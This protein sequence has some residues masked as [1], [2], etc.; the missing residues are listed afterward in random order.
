MAISMKRYIDITSKIQKTYNRRGLEGLVFLPSNAA[1][2]AT[3]ATLTD[4]NA[5]NVITVN[6]DNYG[7]VFADTTDAYKFASQYFGYTSNDGS[8]PSVLNFVKMNEDETHVQAYERVIQEFENFGSFTFL[9]TSISDA[10]IKAVADANASKNFRYLYCQ[11]YNVSSN[12]V[13]EDSA[14][15]EVTTL[16]GVL[17]SDGI[18]GLC[19]VAGDSYGAYMPMAMFAATDYNKTGSASCFMFKQFSG[20][21]AY[22]K[23][24]TTAISF[25]NNNVNYY[26]ETKYNGETISFFQR[27]FNTDGIDTAVFCGEVWFKSECARSLLNMLMNANRVPA[28]ATGIAM[29][30]SA[31]QDPISMALNNGTILPQKE[32]TSTQVN[33]IRLLTNNNSDAVNNIFIYGYYCDVYIV[34]SE[35]GN[36]K[37]A[38]YRIIYSKGDSI[39]EVNGSHIL[40]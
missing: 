5:G 24:D 15:S 25:D 4:F 31:L 27:G 39:R 18:S 37:K 22:V 2:I 1:T 20:Q 33:Q 32:L 10:N 16:I 12:G 11:S 13:L 23:D 34:D 28:N 30:T 19:I 29:V 35:N 40:V 14:T 38:E 8:T 7:A 17:G 6:P 36:E 21:I 26:G 3:G 9:D